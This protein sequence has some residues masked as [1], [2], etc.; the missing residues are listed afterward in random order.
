MVLVFQSMSERLTSSL[1]IGDLTK[2]ATQSSAISTVSRS[3]EG[4]L[5]TGRF[6]LRAFPFYSLGSW[7][8]KFCVLP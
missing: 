7:I 5:N 6:D 3:K 4:I 2:E 1:I 8:Y